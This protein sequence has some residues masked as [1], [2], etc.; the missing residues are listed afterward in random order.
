MTITL[1]LK[2]ITP[3]KLYRFS[4]LLILFIISSTLSLIS[5]NSFYGK[6]RVW[7]CQMEL[8]NEI[9]CIVIDIVIITHIEN[10]KSKRIQNL[11]LAGCKW[12]FSQKSGCFCLEFSKYW[13][14]ECLQK[15]VTSHKFTSIAYFYDRV[16]IMLFLFID[17]LFDANIAQL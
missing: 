13:Q 12:Y 8:I 4:T 14:Q 10:I 11:I 1:T 17:R 3:I 9:V 6:T 2:H 16:T 7:N 5:L 15:A